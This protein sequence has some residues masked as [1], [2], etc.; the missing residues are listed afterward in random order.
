MSEDGWIANPERLDLLRLSM[1]NG[2][3]V[4]IGETLHKRDVLRD[5]RISALGL[6]KEAARILSVY[7]DIPEIVS[8]IDEIESASTS[9]KTKIPKGFLNCN[10][11]GGE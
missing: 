6:L 2:N 8:V 9:L 7:D 10:S 3:V 4:H 1:Q 5:D 11:D